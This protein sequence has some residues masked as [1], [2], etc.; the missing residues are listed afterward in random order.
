[1]A[2]VEAHHRERYKALLEMVESGT[3]LKRATPIK[4]K[5]GICGYIYEGTEPPVKCPACKNP[6]EFYEPANLDF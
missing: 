6:R 3:V 4:W 5:C 1:M 2:R